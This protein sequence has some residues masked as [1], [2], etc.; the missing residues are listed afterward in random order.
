MHLH[1][2][3]GL[4]LVLSLLLSAFH[5]QG[6]DFEVLF[7]RVTGLSP[8]GKLLQVGDGSFYGTTSRGGAHDNGTV[9]KI[10]PDGTH[11]LL[12]S[13]VSDKGSGPAGGL[14]LGSDGSFY[15]TTKYGGVDGYGTVYKITADGTHT[16]LHSFDQTNG[17][18]PSGGLVMGSN[19]SLYGTTFGGGGIDTGTVFRIT[20]SGTHSVVYSFFILSQGYSPAAGLVQGSDGSF[21]GTNYYG[22]ASGYGTVF[23]V[24]TGG[25]YTVLHSFNGTG[26]R[27]PNSD[28][29]QGSDG[30]FYG[31]TFSGGATDHGTL[32]K[33]TAGGTYTLLHSFNSANG[34]SP[35][36]ALVQGS[37]GSFYGATSFGGAS[38]DGTVFSITSSGTHTLL[39]SFDGTASYAP[40][41][42]ALGMDGHFYGT[43][44]RD[45]AS[46]GGSVFKMTASGTLTLLHSFLPLAGHS[47]EGGLVQGGDGSF[48]GTT[49]HGGVNNMGTVF[50]ATP[51]GTQ[52]VLHSFSSANGS[53]PGDAL[54][55]GSDGNFYGTTKYGGASD[56]GTVF[57]I[58]ASGTHTVLLNLN[59]TLGSY[60]EAALVEG[61]DGSFYGTTYAGGVS[62]NGTVFKITAGGTHTL[63]H[64]FSGAG[65][66]YPNAGLVQGSD[67][68]FYGTTTIGG[69]SGFGTVFKITAG[70]T[71]TL[72]HS[73]ND[74]DGA[75]PQGKLV[76]ASDG[77]FYGTTHLGGAN[78]VGT[79]FKITPGGTHTLLYSF[80][81]TPGLKPLA[82]LLKATDGHF[83]GTAG[84]MCIWRLRFTGSTDL[85]YSQATV[86]GAGKPGSGIP[87]LAGWAKLGVPSINDNAHLTFSGQWRADALTG[88]GIFRSG[89]ARSG[90]QLVAANGA[91]VPGMFNAVYLAFKDPLLAPDGAVVW[92]CTLANAPGTT[93]AVKT[94]NDT[95]M[96]LD[97]DGPGGN[98][99]V[100][101][102][103][104]G[105]V[106]AGMTLGGKWAS[107]DSIS[108]SEG[109]VVFLGKLV[110]SAA[111][112]VSTASDTGLW[113]YDRE[114][115]TTSLMMREGDALL[116]SKVK[117]MGALA[118][119]TRAGGQG[120]GVMTSSSEDQVAMRVTLTNGRTAMGVVAAPGG[121]TFLYPQGSG[122]P[123]YGAAAWASFG[124][125][126]QNS[127]AGA[128][129]F[130]AKVVPGTGTATSRDN[131]ALFSEDDDTLTL[132]RR[133]YLSGSAG[134]AG[135]VF[136]GFSDPVNAGGQKMAFIGSMAN[137]SA[138]G[139]T[140]GSND[141]VWFY[142]GTALTLVAREG[143]QPPGVV[144]G[145]RWKSFTTVAL[146]EGRGP[147]FVAKL[148]T[149]R[150]G[151]T[152]AKDT[153]LWA[154]DSAGAIKKLIQEGDAIAGSKVASFQVLTTVPGSPAQTRSFNNRGDVVIQVTSAIG[155]T[156]LVHVVVP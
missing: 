86:P 30:N 151:I 74:T 84:Q 156:H 133:C 31:T 77:N 103:R 44:T 134:I 113:R 33:I 106:A 6:Q 152:T 4:V 144:T 90:L 117:L 149:G 116:G 2:T 24:T 51:D 153:G 101:I 76:Q 23:K 127:P 139:I 29:V 20:E 52:S 80:D 100:M 115:A 128:I 43:T 58:T 99:P 109:A 14:V 97:E 63:L 135:G 50:R 55:L 98:A 92:L 19:G 145:A 123:N 147:I 47:P 110:V 34:R 114:T 40:G 64:S 53:N 142:N 104:E 41:G 48:Y 78:A 154:T 107:F 146:P 36:G 112:G 131:L 137:N 69:A 87:I 7:S 67:G 32:F 124:L 37:D 120:R 108:V 73:F 62:G 85:F 89:M 28:L 66:I 143:A 82:G 121:T 21:Y 130:R 45:G 138:A 27:N 13:F 39:H 10:A 71:H 122:A 141:G 8:S 54:V 56:H 9:F 150:A 155:E 94:S 38:D 46:V 118:T 25:T 65:G 60:P 125:P 126:G 12:H 111:A 16:V 79:V 88:G 91:A 129:C 93:G 35:S 3:Y 70:G 15:G 61:S 1:I 18:N 105:D 136:S 119:R 148:Q 57:K 140:S 75:E 11:T 81:G 96:F 17:S 68:S 102:A 83:Y 26:G 132:V 95:A 72:L 5:A 59:S 49:Y 22:G 42:L